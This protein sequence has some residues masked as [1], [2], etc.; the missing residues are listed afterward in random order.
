MD[1]TDPLTQ[2]CAV[3]WWILMLWP[4]SE[5]S[6]TIQQPNGPMKC[7]TQTFDQRLII[8]IVVFIYQLNIGCSGHIDVVIR[9]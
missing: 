1:R 8:V 6:T 4:E 2:T 3:V 9:F 7:I 5:K